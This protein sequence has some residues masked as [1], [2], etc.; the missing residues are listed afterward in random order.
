MNRILHLVR[1][2]EAEGAHPRHTDKDRALTHQGQQD[3]LQLGDHIKASDC[4]I[5]HII[6]SP[7]IRALSTAYLVARQIN[8]ETKY[9]QTEERI[10]SGGKI[11][12]LKLLN[13]LSE[14]FTEVLLVGHYPTIVELYNYLTLESKTTMSTTELC[15]LKFE[16]PW[17]EVTGGSGFTFNPHST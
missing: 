7:A 11:E 10:Y 15:S 12:I 1:H 6:S 4:T 5:N 3:A 13:A 9:I 8:F 2:A 14:S 17:S 16:I